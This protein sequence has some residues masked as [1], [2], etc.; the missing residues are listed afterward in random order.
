MR[1]MATPIHEIPWLRKLF[2]LCLRNTGWINFYMRHPYTGDLFRLN[3]Y[4]HKGYWYHGKFRA[5]ACMLL[6]QYLIE[7]HFSVI[8]VGGHIGFLTLF[9]AGLAEKG[10][11]VV[12][13]P[14]T[15]NLPYLRKNIENK[16]NIS[17]FEKAVGD[18]EK[19]VKFHLENIT[20]QNNTVLPHYSRFADN[21]TQAFRPDK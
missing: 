9:F 15:N 21:A 8:D 3:L 16:K 4:R 11:V 7:P 2:L 18:E 20:G 1:L 14:G 10:T 12:F 19:L 17:L 5:R 13:E 6:S